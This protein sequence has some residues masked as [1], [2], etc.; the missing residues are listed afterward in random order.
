MFYGPSISANAYLIWTVMFS[1]DSYGY[2]NGILLY[3]GVIDKPILWLQDPQWMMSIVI[4]VVLWM[5][6]GVSFLRSSQAYREST[7]YYE[8]GAIDGIRNRWQELWYITL[9]MMKTT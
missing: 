4:I 3:W 7:G 9:P 6:L 8:A 5:S 2:I 1:G